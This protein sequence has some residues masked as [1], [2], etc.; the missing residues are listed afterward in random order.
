LGAIEFISLS[1]NLDKLEK[2]LKEEKDILRY[3]ILRKE[4]SIS[5]EKT[6]TLQEPKAAKIKLKSAQSKEKEK[7]KAPL[8]ELDKKLEELLKQVDEL[9]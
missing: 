7:E 4:T 8:E 2:K 6:P 1:E 3:L 5:K 9:Q